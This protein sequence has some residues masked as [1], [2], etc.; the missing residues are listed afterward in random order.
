[1]IKA[2]RSW[3]ADRRK[4]PRSVRGFDAAKVSR[5]LNEWVTQS[6]AIDADIR[7]GGRV[8]LARSRDVCTNNVYGRRFLA[9]LSSNVVGPDGVRLQ[10]K[11]KRANGKDLD[12]DANRKIE[13]AW[14]DF[15][16]PRNCTVT[17]KLSF[18]DVCSIVVK[19]L[20]R[21]GEV[22]NKLVRGFGNPHRFA[23]QLLDPEY[24]DHEY[25]DLGKNIV[26]SV[27]LDDWRAPVAYHICKWHPGRN[28]Y[29]YMPLQERQRVPAAD[30]LHVFMA[31]RAEQTRG[32][33]WTASALKEL[34]QLGHYKYSEVVAARVAAAKMG[35]FERSGEGAY[36]YDDK[37]ASGNLIEEVSPGKFQ[38]LPAGY[39]FT[40]FDPTH[41]NTAFA[42]FIKAAL[43]AI[44][45]GLNVSYISLAND[46]TETSYSSGRQG[47][48]EERN[49]YMMLQGFLIEH[50]VQP[51]Y[52]AWLPAAISSGRLAL[53]LREI[54]R[55]NAPLWQGRRWSWIDPDKDISANEKAVRLGVT[56]RTRI[57]GEQ[58]LDLEDTFAEL[59][60][61]K[62]SAAALGIDVSGTI[63][64]QKGAPNEADQNQ[65]N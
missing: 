43:K 32:Y 56:S 48:L 64:N 12:D 23:L 33:P 37:D 44:S 53:P 38:E 47:L 19:G 34:H 58:G 40:A 46:L 18:A 4:P 3:I 24:M 16:L 41:P 5:L 29:P 65:A 13:A 52:D 31:E 42:D 55:W 8:L 28:E 62:N 59:A 49:F 7:Q 1:M 30:V 27:E 11:V 17:Q 14:A 35:F 60:S 50:F 26:M 20:A 22:L 36:P 15:C 6:L 61:E 21:D 10:S 2:L 25:S 9:L 54:E 57:A 51:V 63:G 45:S 39:K